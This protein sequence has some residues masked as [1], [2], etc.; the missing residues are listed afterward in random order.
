[1]TRY[2]Q[3]LSRLVGGINHE[4]LLKELHRIEFYSLVPNDDNRGE[5]GK[6]LRDIFYDE[7]IGPNSKTF[8]R[9]HT[10]SSLL[11]SD[12]LYGHN[13]PKDRY[14]VMKTPC[15]IL[16][17]LIGVAFRMVGELQGRKDAM[18][19]E[20]CFWLLIDNL[21]LHQ[22]DNEAYF[23]DGAVDY[24]RMVIGDFLDRKYKHNGD[25]GLFPLRHPS[26]DQRDVEI[27]Y[28]MCEYLLENYEF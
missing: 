12:D 7:V 16:E 11:S 25:G 17:M 14:S 5:D 19:V 20:E 10:G 23:E 15:T 18:S 3:F 28:Q 9:G 13:I 21:G 22:I 1:M 24:I 6:N 2:F 26:R 4:L 27:W 8:R